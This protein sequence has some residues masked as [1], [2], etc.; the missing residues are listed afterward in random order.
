[1]SVFV[2]AA[3]S[4]CASFSSSSRAS[5]ASARACSGATSARRSKLSASS[6]CLIVTSRPCPRRVRGNLARSSGCRYIARHTWAQSCSYRCCS[7]SSSAPPRPR[8]Q[9]RCGSGDLSQ[10]RRA[11][12]GAG[13]LALRRARCSRRAL[14]GGGGGACDAVAVGYVSLYIMVQF[15]LMYILVP[16]AAALGVDEGKA[17]LA[18]ADSAAHAVEVEVTP[19]V[20]ETCAAPA[21]APGR[22]RA[23]PPRPQRLRAR[24]ARA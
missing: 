12:A 16:R 19:A 7:R 9:R 13:R 11:A 3:T 10:L 18:A 24:R 22:R 4:M 17:K 8:E 21:P 20:E 6:S 5:R 1:M 23:R 2:A 14:T 15:P